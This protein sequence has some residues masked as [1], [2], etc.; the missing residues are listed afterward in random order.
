MGLHP[1][2]N[3]LDPAG[4]QTGWR[5]RGWKRPTRFLARTFRRRQHGHRG[6]DVGQHDE[7]GGLGAQRQRNSLDP[8]VR[9][10]LSV[11][12]SAA[13]Q[14]RRGAAAT[15]CKNLANLARQSNGLGCWQAWNRKVRRQ[16]PGMRTALCTTAK[17]CSNDPRAAWVITRKA[18]AEH[19]STLLLA[20]PRREDAPSVAS[21]LAH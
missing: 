17:S 6:W 3:G 10:I 13:P 9:G 12:R 8:A 11:G 15:T 2:R 4:Q 14:W 21:L 7:R 20:R 16:T 5:R 1:Q 19:I 18:Q